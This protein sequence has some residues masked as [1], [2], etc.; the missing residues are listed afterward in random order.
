MID[1]TQDYLIIENNIVTNVCVWDGNP[2]TWTPP[3][4]TLMLTKANTE[5]IVWFFD[6]SLQDWVLRQQEGA[7][8]IGF[9]WNGT[10]CTTNQSKPEVPVQ[11]VASGTQEL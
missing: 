3:D 11:P 10:A 4:N 8:D 5:A 1:M 7:G 2:S 9:T 6:E